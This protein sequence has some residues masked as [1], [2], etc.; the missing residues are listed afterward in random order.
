MEINVSPCPE[1]EIR[2][3]DQALMEAFEL[4]MARGRKCQC[5]S[6]N[7]VDSR[8]TGIYEQP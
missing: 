5:V 3:S 6:E 2:A 8:N 7:E 4:L 1:Y